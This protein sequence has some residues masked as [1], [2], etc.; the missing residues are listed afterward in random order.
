MARK[1]NEELLA[2]S[3]G[4]VAEESTTTN[5]AGMYVIRDPET[6][7]VIAR[8]VA[9]YHPKF[10]SAQ[11]DGY[12]RAGY[13]FERPLTADDMKQ[14]EFGNIS[15]VQ[16]DALAAGVTQRGTDTVPRSEFDEM[17]K[18]MKAQSAELERLAKLAAPASTEGAVI[19][20]PDNA[21]DKA[22][23]AD[24]AKSDKN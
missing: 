12:I 20:A 10:G 8:A 5:P 7:E 22:A 13:V 9:M 17:V 2:A 3:A 23:Q 21:A 19:Q 18:T 15:P 4:E 16:N 24:A 1:T 6:R 14:P 11:A